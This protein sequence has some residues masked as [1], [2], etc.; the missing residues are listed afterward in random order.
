MRSPMPNS[1]NQAIITWQQ[2]AGRHHLPW[3]HPRTPYRVWLSE[4]M[5][6][7]TQVATVIPYFERFLARFPDVASLA[8]ASED[9]VFSLWSGLG[10]YRRARMLHKAAQQIIDKHDGIFPDTFDD[11]MQLPGIGRSTAGAIL[12]QAYGKQAAILDGNVR[13]ILARLHALSDPSDQTLWQLA[14]RYLPETD[15]TAYTQGLMDLGA[16]VCT[17][18]RPRCQDCPVQTHCLAYQQ[19][20]PTAYPARRARKSSPTHEVFWVLVSD[21][22]QGLLFHKRPDI[23]VWAG[24]WS[25]P[26]CDAASDPVLWARDQLGLTLNVK[27]TLATRP[28]TFSHFRLL[29]TPIVMEYDLQASASCAVKESCYTWLDKTE[30]L[31]KGLPAPVRA[32]LLDL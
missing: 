12:A 2:A 6:Q 26:Q 22:S 7:Q 10:Y 17:K 27:T 23:G 32:L 29:I 4:V 18:H 9:D 15:I 13:R 5:L 30:A 28:H 3:Q 25:F 11:L 16:T 14:E 31:T 19:G 1:F 21:P 24:L 20:D 8:A